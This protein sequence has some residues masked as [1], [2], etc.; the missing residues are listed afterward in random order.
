MT[1]SSVSN[2]PAHQCSDC[3][4]GD[5]E[6]AQGLRKK[7]D[8]M[9]V[10]QAAEARRQTR[11]GVVLGYAPRPVLGL[12]GHGSL[13]GQ[14]EREP[15]NTRHP[16]KAAWQISFSPSLRTCETISVFADAPRHVTGGDRRSGWSAQSRDVWL[17]VKC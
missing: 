1:G 9:R 17:W 12:L 4:R 5:L 2:Y 6:R 14:Y 13:F 8:Q 11:K 15:L 3:R 10:D 7:V 16:T